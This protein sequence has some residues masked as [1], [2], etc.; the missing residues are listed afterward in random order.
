VLR[1]LERSPA[2]PAAA[3]VRAAVQAEGWVH[4]VPEGLGEQEETRQRDLG[5]LVTLA[6]TFDGGARTAAELVADLHERFREEGTARGVHLLT[7]HRAKG[8]EFDAVFLPR[9]EEG[10]LPIRQARTP[11]LVAEERRLLYVGLTRARV[12]LVLTRTTQRAA[13][14]FLSELRPP[15]RRRQSVRTGAP[16]QDDPLLAALRV[17]RR[18]RARADGVPAY[19]VFHDRTLDAIAAAAPGSTFELAE[20][21]GVG[22][23]KLDRYGDEVLALVASASQVRAQEAAHEVEGRSML[24]PTPE[25]GSPAERGRRGAGRA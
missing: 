25:P 15:E 10:E 21:P 24:G 2:E 14:R 20:V 19:L 18:Q 12:H 4:P 6:E 5:R 7:L 16:G 22:P 8:L 13:S 3:A 9:L 1:A 17:W 11:A 23:A